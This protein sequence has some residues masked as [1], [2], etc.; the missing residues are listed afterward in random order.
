M[1]ASCHELIAEGGERELAAAAA[2]AFDA[3]AAHA[4]AVLYL[5]ERPAALSVA[6]AA[7]H[8]R[9]SR[10]RGWRR[11]GRGWRRRDVRGGAGGAARSRRTARAAKGP[12]AWDPTDGNLAAAAAATTTATT[13]KAKERGGWGRRL[14]EA[15][16]VLVAGVEDVSVVPESLR[17][18]FTHEVEAKPPT[19]AERLATLRACLGRC[20]N[21]RL[22]R[23]LPNDPS[24]PTPALSRRMRRAS[25][26]RTS[27]RRRRRRPARWPATRALA[28]HAAAR[29]RP[30]TNAPVT[31]ADARAAT[32]WS[33]RRAAAAV[34]T[35]SVPT[36]RWDDVG[37]LDE[38]KAAIRDV[39]ELPL[40]G[41]PGS[42]RFAV[43]RVAAR[44]A[45]YG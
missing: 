12:N 6:A 10:R 3:A 5:R 31:G 25:P 21:V 37:R 17:Q 9:R 36:T 20:P 7:C 42:G 44:A 2:A 26:T 28:A 16:V 45:W 19:E 24:P 14:N 22:R 34:G 43:R 27:R 40:A 30:P 29:S 4:P 8:R 33:E 23:T 39:V 35:P 11:G 38:V 32:E 41:R 18:C 1:C 15:I 13:V